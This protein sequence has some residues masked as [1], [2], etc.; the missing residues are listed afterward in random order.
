MKKVMLVFAVFF[1]FILNAQEDYYTMYS[2]VVEPQD[3]ATVY[4]LVDDYYSKN[5]PEGVFVRLF[6]N[7]FKDQ[8]NKA[9]HSI[10]FL[11]TQEAVGNMY[12]GGENDKFALFL[13]KLNQHI[14]EGAGSAMGRHIA[15]YGDTSTRYPAQ[16]YYLLDVADTE[17]FDAGY[18]KFHSKH[19]PPG[20]LVNMGTTIAGQG[21]GNFN[22]W[23]IIA[24]KDVKTALGGPNKLLSGAALTAREKGWAEFR[25][26]DG[27]VE[28]VG[29]GMRVLLGA[30]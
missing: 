22:R 5:K 20:V 7:H 14:K 6:E 25:A 2:F 18:K 12:G 13:T 27:G 19:N 16:R 1:A 17:K 28:V 3:E 9:T 15:I 21:T 10:V 11:G 26:T 23:V 29:S 30:W 8:R 24:F 4:K